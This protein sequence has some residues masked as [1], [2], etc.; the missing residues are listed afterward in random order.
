M[1]QW[2]VDAAKE[3]RA[4]VIGLSD[5]STE[6]LATIIAKHA[7]QP[8]VIPAEVAAKAGEIHRTPESLCSV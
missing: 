3:F 5:L 4:T 1:A 2:A 7:P 8:P 6:K